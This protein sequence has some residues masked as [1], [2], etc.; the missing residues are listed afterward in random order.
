M[1]TV[2]DTTVPPIC[3]HDVEFS[4]W[5]HGSGHFRNV[6][7]AA[8]R[9]PTPSSSTP[10][11]PERPWLTAGDVARALRVDLKTVHNWVAR[12][13]LRGRKTRGG[14]LRFRHV[15]LVR[16]ACRLG[17]PMPEVFRVPDCRALAVGI[18]ESAAQSL[19]ARLVP[20]L[21]T[22]ALEL[23]TDEYDA[24]VID[25][26]GIVLTDLVALLSSVRRCTVTSDLAIVVLHD[27]ASVRSDLS[28]SGAD[29]VVPVAD[30][31]AALHLVTGYGGA[32]P[33]RVP[34]PECVS[35]VVPAGTTELF[36]AHPAEGT[37]SETDRPSA[38]DPRRFLPPADVW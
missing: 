35:S 31:A 5:I 27:D 25:A 32:L 2:P 26:S 10:I 36:A 18:D 4:I 3:S 16:Y 23:A 15:E 28:D 6:D 1:F 14:H 19:G 8:A 37:A 20:D 29:A 9:N 22:A 17:L 24:L 34:A 13:K 11:P 33:E 21:I 12:G 30:I 7:T 38:I